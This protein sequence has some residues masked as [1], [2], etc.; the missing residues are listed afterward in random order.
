MAKKLISIVLSVILVFSTFVIGSFAGDTITDDDR[1]YYPEEELAITDPKERIL[2][3][4]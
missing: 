1:D 4:R 3:F 2:S